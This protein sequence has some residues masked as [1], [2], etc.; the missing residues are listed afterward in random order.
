M[1]FGK[2]KIVMEQKADVGLISEMPSQSE[3][4]RNYDRE[5]QKLKRDAEKA[6]FTKA[7]QNIEWTTLKEKWIHNMSVNI[8]ARRRQLADESDEQPAQPSNPAKEL[9]VAQASRR[10]LDL[11]QPRAEK[12][13]AHRRVARPEASVPRTRAGKPRRRPRNKYPREARRYRPY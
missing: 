12:P 11:K 1:S 5:T 9:Q 2:Y 6:H 3:L 7:L 8:L 13:I 4:R 10:S